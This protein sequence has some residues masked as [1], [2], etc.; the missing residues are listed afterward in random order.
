MS[1]KTPEIM[2]SSGRRRLF[3]LDFQEGLHYPGVEVLAGL[4]LQV[5]NDLVHRPG[6]AVGP[7]RREG[8]PDVHYREDAGRQW[9]LLPF[10]PPGVAAAV[11]FLVVAVGDVQG[12]PQIGDGGQEPEGLVRVLA[13][14][15]PLLRGQRTRFQ[16]DAVRNADLADVVQQG[17]PAHVIQFL[18]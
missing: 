18:A 10:Q 5:V 16:Q 12:R 9:N 14:D 3:R 17:P 1:T 6:V 13:H 8:V 2:S 15:F 7:I 11:P 4:L